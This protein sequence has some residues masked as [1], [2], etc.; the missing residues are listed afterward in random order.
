MRWK[1]SGRWIVILLLIGV[2]TSLLAGCGGGQTPTPTSS[3][4][5]EVVAVLYGHAD[6]GTWD[7]SAYQ[8]LLKAQKE[9]PFDLKLAEAV[10]T[11]DAEKVIRDWAG[12]EPALLFAHSDI[13]TDAILNVAKQFPKVIF[14]GEAQI[15]PRTKLDVPEIAKY[16]PDKTPENFLFTGDTPFEGNYLAGYAAALLTKSGVIGVLQ[17][18]EAP[19]L[20]RYTNAFYF[21]AQAAKP[22]VKVNVVYVGDYIAPA[23]TRDAV[24]SMKQQGADVIFSQMD[25]NSAILESAAQGILC[26][27]MYMDKQSFDPKT[28][29]TSVVMEWYGP[30]KALIEAISKGE[31]KAYREQ[32]YF[33]GL[34]ASDDS[35]HLGEWGTAVPESVKQAVAAVEAKIKSGEVKVQIVDEVLVK[36]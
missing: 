30:L 29:A 17:P 3:K 22:S 5:M 23:E 10:S 19:P 13:Y 7:P 8:G 11:Q 25:D 1:T 2:V 36:P 33:R 28:V 21:G 31:F 35:V 4:P 26:I 20:N 16:A 15:D 27:P 34:S 18:F 6:E 9:I 14:L 12:K 32:Y 24:E